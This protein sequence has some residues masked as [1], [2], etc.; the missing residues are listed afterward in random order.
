[1]L[2]FNRIPT[3][4]GEM[5]LEEF[6]KPLGMTQAAFAEQIDIPLQLLD[7]IIQ[8]KRGVTSE[9]AWLLAQAL[10]TTPQFWLNLQR[11]HDLVKKRVDS[12]NFIRGK[13]QKLRFL[14]RLSVFIND[15]FR[16]LGDPV[17]LNE[18]LAPV[19]PG[20]ILMEEFLK[21]MNLSQNRLAFSMGVSARRINEIV[22]GK[23]GITADTALRLA[24]YFDMSPQFWMGIQMDYALN[25]AE[26]ELSGRL[27]HE[28]RPHPFTARATP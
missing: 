12:A 17:M 22:L 2:P 23:R 13:L 19:H 16:S 27:E 7:E 4:P 5:L 14:S 10:D 8:G 25:V 9:T 24:R 26:D 3:H 15:M 1:M 18:K 20:E 11:N 21:P 28:V 6:I